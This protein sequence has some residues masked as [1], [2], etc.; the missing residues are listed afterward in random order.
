MFAERTDRSSNPCHST[1]FSPA[2][3]V[4]DV[5]IGESSKTEE[6]LDIIIEPRSSKRNEVG[7]KDTKVKSLQQHHHHHEQQ[8]G[9]SSHNKVKEDEK[10]C[11]V[12]NI[13]S[14]KSSRGGR[15]AV[16]L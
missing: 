6:M 11:K 8:R 14:G 4:L 2:E 1:Q 5:P 10:T 15:M 9:E 3:P 13:S 12:R 7:K 16:R